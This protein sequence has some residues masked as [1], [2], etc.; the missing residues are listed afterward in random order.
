[1]LFVVILSVVWTYFPFWCP[2]H[3]NNKQTKIEL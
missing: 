2:E 1:L 3:C